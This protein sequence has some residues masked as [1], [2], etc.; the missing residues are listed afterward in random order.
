MAATTRFRLTDEE[1]ID[2]FDVQ[3]PDLLERRPDL[4]LRIYHAFM[5][6]FATKAEVAVAG[7][8]HSRRAQL[9]REAGFDVIEPEEDALV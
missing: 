7:A 5:K 3:L 2:L 8:I 6:A 9:L 4:E 1:L